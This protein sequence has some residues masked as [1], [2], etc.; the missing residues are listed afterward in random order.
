MNSFL[1][2]E[3]LV[4]LEIAGTSPPL[5]DNPQADLIR[6]KGDEHEAAYLASLRVAGKTVV[7]P[8]DAE[9]AARLIR[10][11]TAD[12]IYQPEFEDPA[13]WRGR[14]DF[15]ELQ[16]GGTYEV[17]DTKLARHAKPYYILQLCFYSE[18]VARIQGRAPRQMHVVLGSGERASFRPEEFGAY[19]RRVRKRLEQFV[20]NPPPTE[21]WPV[22]HCAIC[23]FRSLCEAYWEETDS[24]SRVYGMRR[25][26]RG[27]LADLGVSTLA[28]LAHAQ[29][30][31]EKFDRI[32]EHAELQ[33]WARE[34]NAD[35]YVL[36][37]PQPELGFALL[38][39]PSPGDLFFDFEGNPFWDSEGSLEYL[40]GILD[41]DGNFTPLH[42]HDHD[43]ERA[44]FEAFIDLVR[45][46]LARH[47]DLHVYHYAAYEI[48]A[49]RRLMG[50]H[51]TREAE[52][53]DLLRRGVFVD[54]LKVVRN[55]LRASRRGY[56]LKEM[57]AF[58]DF[59][60][61]AEI[62]EGGTSIIVF[63]QWMQSREP[64]LIEQLDAYNRED[65]IAT[66]LLRDWLLELRA[67]A[68]A[69]FGP[70]PQP[71]PK[72]PRETPPRKAER[73]AL[74]AQL[75][76]AGEELAAHLLD[77]HDRERKPV[78]WA[79]FD[80]LEMS[81]DELVEDAESIGKLEL[82]GGPEPVLRSHAYTFTFPPQEHKLGPNQD[83]AE[84]TTGNNAGEITALD[85]DARSLV[86]KRG[87]SLDDV[88][89]PDALIPKDVYRTN[90]QEDALE[91]IGH[92]L[93]A[94]DR[95]YPAVE[96]ILRREPFE[97]DVQHD[98]LT[99]LVLSLDR[100]HLVIQGPPGSGKT[101]TI[102]RLIPALVAA[103]K[104][105]GVASQ[106]HKAIHNVLD[107]I[108]APYVGK[109][110]ASG[111]NPESYYSGDHVDNVTDNDEVVDCDVAAGTAWLFADPTHDQRLDYL[112][113]DEAGQVSLADALAMAT[114]ARN[115]ILVGD[116]Q[117]LAQV[118]QGS[119]PP[120]SGASVLT[121]LLGDA[122]T[123]PPDRGVFLERT[124]R[125]HPDICTYISEEFYEGRLEPDSVT[126][127]RTTPL[128][129]GLRYV[130]VAH[131]GNRQD[132]REEVDAVR[133]EVDA[134]LAA[135]VTD[136]MVVAPYNAQV[137]AL[138]EALP[139]SVRVGTVDKFQGQE[140]D[141]V[142]Y[143]M[144]SSSGEDVPRGLE[145]L[146][147]RNR[148]NVAISRARCLAYLVASP[149]LLEVNCRTIPQMRLANALC[150]F[151]ELAT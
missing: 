24:L 50:R 35:K 75:L 64:A 25:N 68:V 5:V 1:E 133:E 104:T 14:A 135:G 8:D 76:E 42:A 3:H 6:R 108:D 144:A 56:G 107:A 125:L 61:R 132:S 62:K 150:R 12:V 92:S 70:L 44:A 77:Y 46:R 149:R 74:R 86:L 109:K 138:R 117:Q 66:R 31:P 115:V 19:Y 55:G 98:H 81:A 60:R 95:R 48:T 131:E 29:G 114:C 41:V 96:S 17:V 11:A 23:D 126:A 15:L 85:R 4:A 127:T 28:E 106:S 124:F 84:P 39:D 119:H 122:E 26:N 128:G 18:Q 33:L 49:L 34:N 58:L 129:T 83:V 93:L 97:R 151:V 37:Q 116:P 139:D 100:R 10:E 72:E 30:L 102:G 136:I 103:G 113:I 89:L 91:R 121:H 7:E 146:L 94:R 45:D 118:L 53:D 51:G 79:F 20:A 47:P 110:K 52:L 59:E 142:L 130:D 36:Q 57:E 67:E 143:S 134:L 40:W 38:P 137:N 88:P 120:G 99:Q 112:F 69:R 101:W 80:R 2:C 123:I 148:L 87:P 82:T 111:G 13:G 73:A 21:P 22:Q 27:E 65:C 140:A 90:D 145:F 16:T 105:V 9:D 78:W 71:E 43:T 54:L 32:H 141:V 63:E 147:S